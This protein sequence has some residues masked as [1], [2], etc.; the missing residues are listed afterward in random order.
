MTLL[1]IMR[2]PP[3]ARR[4]A[5]FL[6]LAAD[7]SSLAGCTT[8]W[9]LKSSCTKGSQ[10][11]EKT[12]GNRDATSPFPGLLQALLS[13]HSDLIA[14]NELRS[15]QNIGDQRRDARIQ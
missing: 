15:F 8:Q 3:F 5:P 2:A 12:L 10:S 14:Q 7:V 1:S 6:P 11:L 9:V 4:V 13:T